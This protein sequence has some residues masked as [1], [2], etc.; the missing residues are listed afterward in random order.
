AVIEFARNVLGYEDA[1]STEFSIKTKYPVIDLMEEQKKIT[2]KG[3]TMRL[4]SYPCVLTPGT[5]SAKVYGTDKINERHRHRYEFNSAYKNVFEKA[6]LTI[7]GTSPDG[8]L[9]E[10]VE[11]KDHPWFAACQFHPEFKS[12]PLKAHPLFKGF[13]GAAIAK[14]G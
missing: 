5:I 6:G 9:V 3:G 11:I 13:I 1:D 4:G 12:T 8:T 2:A 7:A 14:R 10:I